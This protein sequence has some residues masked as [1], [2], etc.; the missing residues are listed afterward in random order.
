MEWD[1][2]AI[3]GYKARILL[4]EP[5]AVTSYFGDVTRT[6]SHPD[7]PLLWPLALRTL[8]S[9]AGQVDLSSVK[10]LGVMLFAALLALFHG[11]LARAGNR[12]GALLFTLVLSG[13]PMLQAQSVR[14]MAD[15]PLGFLLFGVVSGV[16]AYLREGHR[17]DLRAAGVL[18]AGVLF[19]KSEG[20]PLL[21]IVVLSSVVTLLVS[22]RRRD[23]PAAFLFVGILPL[24]LTAPWFLFRHGIPKLHEDYA[25]RIQDLPANLHLVPDILGRYL[26]YLGAPADWLGFWPLASLAILLG[27]RHW[28]RSP[29]LLPALVLAQA[30]VLYVV[31]FAVNPWPPAELMEIAAARLALQVAPIAAWLA[32]SVFQSARLWPWSASRAEG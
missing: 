32:F 10:L 31:V 6:Y 7:Y 20:M 21:G 17:E 9:S 30:A 16:G 4:H 27:V 28:R 2:I 3:W 12:T 25:V 5:V 14:M 13:L 24:A 1:V 8:W 29:A 15:V 11:Q 26:V 18:A 22:G 23:V 19:T